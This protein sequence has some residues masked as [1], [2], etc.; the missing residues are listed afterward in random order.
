MRGLISVLY[1]CSL[2]RGVAM[3]NL[4]SLLSCC[5]AMAAF[6]IVCLLKRR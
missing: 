1:K 5:L 2:V 3:W 6:C 4:C